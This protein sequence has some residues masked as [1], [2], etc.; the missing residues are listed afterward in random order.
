M[1]DRFA[2]MGI[3]VTVPELDGGDFRNTT[4]TQQLRV[5]SR[6]AGE[7]R[8]DMLIGS[9]LGGYLAALHAARAPDSVPLLVLL[10]PAFDFANRLGLALGTGAKAWQSLGQHQFFHYRTRRDEPLAW[11]FMEDAQRYESFPDVLSATRIL[12]G[13]HD[14]SVPPALS[15]QFAHERSNVRLELLDTD[16]Q[17]LDNTEEIWHR[18]RD[19]HHEAQA[20][21]G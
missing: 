4:L 7:L 2:E 18:I 15:E 1:A 21:R 8:P 17:M 12:H 5:V 11:G 10:A 16:H 6:L 20:M 14:E 3:E 19:F 13:R 9:S